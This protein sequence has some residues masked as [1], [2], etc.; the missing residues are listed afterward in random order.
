MKYSCEIEVN[1]PFE[2]VAELWANEKHFKEWQDKFEAIELLEGERETEDS[3]S[4]I[5]FNNGKMILMETILIANL[6][7][8][9][10]ALYEHKH[11]SNTQHTKF[12]YL[13]N[14]TTLFTSNVAYVKFNGFMPKMMAKLFPG[15]FKKQSEKWM[16]QFK[17]YAEKTLN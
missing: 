4:K 1:A 15:L 3:K 16:N 10:K 7:H 9:K 13:G 8:E 17:C 12:K 14:G 6:P 5:S 2:K 11:M